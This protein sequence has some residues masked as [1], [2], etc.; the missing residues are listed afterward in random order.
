MK[1]RIENMNN[2]TN[3]F[4]RLPVGT[5]VWH[6]NFG[7]GCVFSYDACDETSCG[8]D[9]IRHGK[10]CVSCDDLVPPMKKTIKV[11]TCD[12]VS[13]TDIVPR[14]WDKWFWESISE[15]APFSWGDN[16]RSLV[17]ANDFARHCEQCLDDSVKV[18]RFLKKVRDLGDMYIDLES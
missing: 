5:K 11:Q 7:T 8:V 6:P 13:A 3:P 4:G 9:F 2:Q 17:T 12:F 1:R 14:G 10:Y 16:N 15:N 18:K